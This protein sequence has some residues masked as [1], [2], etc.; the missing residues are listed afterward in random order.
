MPLTLPSWD[1]HT[2]AARNELSETPLTLARRITVRG[3]WSTATTAPAIAGAV[4]FLLTGTHGTCP[5][6][7]ISLVVPASRP[8]DIRRGSCDNLRSCFRL[9]ALAFVSTEWKGE[10]EEDGEAQ[11]GQTAEYADGHGLPGLR[12]RGEL[13]TDGG[14]AA[15]TGSGRTTGR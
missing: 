11:M 2:A 10:G 5:G 9:W 15:A 7:E 12:R 1:R 3:V 6:L 13:R 14:T 8:F 4:F